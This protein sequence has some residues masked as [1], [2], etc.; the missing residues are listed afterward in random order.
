MDGFRDN[1]YGEPTNRWYGEGEGEGEG[2][3]GD[4]VMWTGEGKGDLKK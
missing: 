1:L 2:E 4:E 3:V